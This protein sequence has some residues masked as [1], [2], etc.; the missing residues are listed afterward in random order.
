MDIEV[1]KY[2]TVGH[3]AHNQNYLLDTSKGKLMLRVYANTQFENAAKEYKVLT[4]LG[5]FLG[6]KPYYMRARCWNTITWC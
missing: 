1:N 3:G 4:K 2:S 5:G 6:P